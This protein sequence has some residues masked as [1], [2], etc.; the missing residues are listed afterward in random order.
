MYCIDEIYER[1][2]PGYG[3]SW[4]EAKPLYSIQFLTLEAA[5]EYCKFFN[6]KYKDQWPKLQPHL[7]SVEDIKAWEKEQQR[8]Y[9]KSEQHHLLTRD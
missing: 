1:Y 7:M 9:E 2:I 5:E 8:E 6:E 3:G 4:L